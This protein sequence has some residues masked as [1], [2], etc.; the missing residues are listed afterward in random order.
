MHQHGPRRVPWVNPRGLPR[1]FLHDT[2]RLVYV[3]P[4]LR[5]SSSTPE[6]FFSPR[7][8]RE[9]HIDD[10]PVQ[11]ALEVQEVGLYPA[12]VPPERRRDPDVGARGRLSSPT[13]HEPGVDATLRDNGFRVGHTLAVGKADGSPRLSPT[14]TSPLST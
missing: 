11:I 10:P 12:L 9:A 4:D 5:L 1:R 6:N 2:P 14:T 13:E 7:I 3:A 8:L